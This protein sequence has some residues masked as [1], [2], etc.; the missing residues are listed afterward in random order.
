MINIS[1]ELNGRISELHSILWNISK[2]Q[3][4]WDICSLLHFLRIYGYFSKKYVCNIHTWHNERN[5]IFCLFGTFRIHP[6]Y[7]SNY[8]MK[9]I[10]NFGWVIFIEFAFQTGVLSEFG[11]ALGIYAFF[12]WMLN[13]LTFSTLN[14]FYFAELH[15]FDLAIG[16]FGAFILLIMT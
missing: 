11:L 8:T 3:G 2:L 7:R 1:Y 15:P 10:I 12:R 9:N 4:K 6:R 13:F 16:R 14:I 5:S